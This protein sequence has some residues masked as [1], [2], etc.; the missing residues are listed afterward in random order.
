M[1]LRA[2]TR[3]FRTTSWPGAAVIAAGTAALL[4]TL[5]PS[6]LAASEWTHWRG[7]NQDGTS[8]ETDLISSW[9]LDGENLIWRAD[10]S[11]RSTAVVFARLAKNLDLSADDFLVI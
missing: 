9:S 1:T 7:P 8:P 11:G 5:L 2:L 4:L 10:F 3:S 6:S